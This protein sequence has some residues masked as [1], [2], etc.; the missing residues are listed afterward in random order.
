MFPVCLWKPGE[1]SNSVV[2]Q[3]RLLTLLVPSLAA[4][5][6]SVESPIVNGSAPDA[7]RTLLSRSSITE[8]PISGMEAQL[9]RLFGV[10][11]PEEELPV[12]AV[13]HVLDYGEIVPGWRMRCDPVYLVPGHN[14]L[15]LAG[16]DEL[17][18]TLEES[19][20][21][22]GEL[23]TFYAEKEWSFEAPE[24][25]RWYL[26]LPQAPQLLTHPLPKVMGYS[27]ERY[28][29]RGQDAVEWHTLI[30]EVQMFL[31]CSRVNRQRNL[32]G[33]PTINSLWFW[34]GGALP[35]IQDSSWNRIWS[36]DVVG[37]ALARIADIP[38]L[39]VPETANQWLSETSGGKELLVLDKGR[40]ISR[41]EESRTWL[42]LLG[43]LD[44]QWFAPL[45]AALKKGE[46]ERLEIYGGGN[47]LF[48]LTPRA[49]WRFWRHRPDIATLLGSDE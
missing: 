37:R 49:L 12:A 11:K 18:I 10:L 9:F 3:Q 17:D 48:Q 32:C 28:L 14:S 44:E 38:C 36:N 21:L 15:I 8:L 24:P 45:L 43:E 31:H 6:N 40:Y 26:T 4:P 20:S 1:S 5:L 27:I 39:P 22:I 16:N 19:N 7:L 13:T 33:K 34:G 35:A 25:S 46:L 23:N 29:P 30:A 41:F 42:Q 2:Q 47:R